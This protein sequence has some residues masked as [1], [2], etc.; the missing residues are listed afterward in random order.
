M[1]VALHL[2][3]QLGGDWR[4]AP[5]VDAFAY[6]DDAAPEPPIDLFHVAQ[7]GPLVEAAFRQIDQVRSVVGVAARER[8]GGGEKAC[9]A[10]HDYAHIDAGN[11]ADV[12]ADSGKGPGY[13]TG[14]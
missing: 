8:S 3:H 14:G 4:A 5:V 6:R 12:E 2:S 13:E 10:A 7:E 11:G 1:G 9:V